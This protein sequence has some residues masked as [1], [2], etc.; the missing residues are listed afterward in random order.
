MTTRQEVEKLAMR[1]PLIRAAIHRAY[2][3]SP[4]IAFKSDADKWTH[5]LQELVQLMCARH[6]LEFDTLMRYINRYG[7]HLSA[8]REE[9]EMI[10]ND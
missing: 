6:E 8:D 2:A 10:P 5:V 4:D 1:D 7:S 9:V 3:P